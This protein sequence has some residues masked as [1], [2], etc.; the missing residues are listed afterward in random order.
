M[1][2]RPLIVTVLRTDKVRRIFATVGRLSSAGSETLGR[3]ETVLSY[4]LERSILQAPIEES[5]SKLTTTGSAYCL[6]SKE[7]S[8]V[9][10]KTCQLTN[11]LL[12]NIDERGEQHSRR[13]R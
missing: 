8:V 13:F 7:F 2:T 9:V 1:T 5:V 6:V 11:G 12:Y 3:K 4:V 10:A